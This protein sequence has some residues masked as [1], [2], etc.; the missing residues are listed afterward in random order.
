MKSKITNTER[1]FGY[2]LGTLV[3]LYFI[4]QAFLT[5]KSCTGA[6][7]QRTE[8]VK[9]DNKLIDTL[10]IERIIEIPRDYWTDT[11]KIKVE[12][13]EA[14]RSLSYWDSYRLEMYRMAQRLVNKYEFSISPVRLY[15]YIMKTVYAEC[16][17][18]FHFQ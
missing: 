4:G 2:Y 14:F 17:L 3:L 15:D 5:L 12:H 1:N 18:E 6:L 9:I 13:L 10:E 16:N 7:V 8:T 11:G